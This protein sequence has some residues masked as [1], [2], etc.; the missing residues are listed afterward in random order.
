VTQ[1]AFSF[2]T[3]PFLVLGFSDS[4]KVW[5]RVYFYPVIGVAL[6]MGF[7][8]SPAKP[9]LKK[10]IEQRSSAAGVQLRKSASTE[11]LAAGGSRDREPLV[12][13][14]L[15]SDLSRDVG[16]AV[17]EARIQ[18]AEKQKNLR[19]RTFEVKDGKAT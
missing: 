7:F 19:A 14:G 8:A 9:M 12:G 4:I 1:C 3:T 16:E 2:V 15:S 10:K 6:S 11:S 17:D 13:P 5:A 18:W